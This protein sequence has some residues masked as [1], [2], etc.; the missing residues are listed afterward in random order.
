MIYGTSVNA[1]SENVYLGKLRLQYV[2]ALCIF[3]VSV[4]VVH[5]FVFS[6]SRA[7]GNLPAPALY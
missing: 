1:A 3:F 6:F 7:A 2:F 5:R 4:E